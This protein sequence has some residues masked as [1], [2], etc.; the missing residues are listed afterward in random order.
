MK[1]SEIRFVY[2][3]VSLCVWFHLCVC[4]C[5]YVC[6]CFSVHTNVYMCNFRFGYSSGV[7]DWA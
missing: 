2:A 1:L 4:V 7:V 5:V 3:C 6:V